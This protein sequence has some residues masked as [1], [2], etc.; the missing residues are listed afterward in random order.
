MLETKLELIVKDETTS[1][2][3]TLKRPNNDINQRQNSS[4]VTSVV[5]EC[6]SLEEANDWIDKI[7]D[8]QSKLKWPS[9]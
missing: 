1:K 7:R 2:I 5:I 8:I 9:F 3:F 4:S 6:E